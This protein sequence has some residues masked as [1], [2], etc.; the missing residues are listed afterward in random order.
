MSQ[1]DGT[2]E[3]TLN[4]AQERVTPDELAKAVAAMEARRDAE[5][6]HQTNTIPLGE[7]VR[8]LGLDATPE[9]LLS[10]VRHQR[11]QRETPSPSPSPSRPNRKQDS[12][13]PLFIGA[14]GPI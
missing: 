10:E 8:Q 14:F 4:A 13:L 9:E 12:P 5:T 11:A 7:A 1:Q 2:Q 6:R 3:P